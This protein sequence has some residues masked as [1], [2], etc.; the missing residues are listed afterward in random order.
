MKYTGHVSVGQY[1]F[2]G[3]ELEGSAED[4]IEA[5]K[6]LKK[7]WRGSLSPPGPGLPEPEW[8][9]LLDEYTSTGFVVNG[10]NVWELLDEKQR[11]VINEIKKSKKRTNK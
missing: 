5:F 2:I 10:G 8:R 4:A 7:K 11:H 6:E 9:K 1:E 3:F